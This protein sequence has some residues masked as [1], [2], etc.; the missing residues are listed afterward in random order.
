[1][2]NRKSNWVLFGLF[3]IWFIIFILFSYSHPR[4]LLQD[5]IHLKEGQVILT[6]EML[7]SNGQVTLSGEW[8]FYWDQQLSD[9][10]IA[11]GDNNSNIVS[12]P[13][14]W[15]RYTHNGK[16]LP[17]FGHGTYHLKIFVEN[18]G[19]YGIKIPTLSTA[20]S[21]YIDDQLIYQSGVAG[22][23]AEQTS[24]QYKSGLVLF[25]VKDTEFDLIIHISNYLYARGGMW[26][27]LDFGTANQL[28][29]IYANEK[30]TDLFIL[31]SV[32][33][34][35]IYHLILFTMR[36]KQK[37]Y[38]LFGL[39]SL[40]VAIRMLI[41][42][43]VYLVDILSGVNVWWFVFFEYLTYYAGIPLLLMYFY[44]LYPKEFS[45]RFIKIV[46]VV[47]SLFVLTTIV[48]PVHVFTQFIYGYHFVLII[49]LFVLLHNIFKTVRHKR[50]GSGIQLIAILTFGITMIHDV[51]YNLNWLQIFNRQIVP[52]GMFTLIF[53]QA[54]LIARRFSTVY[55]DMEKATEQLLL[56]DKE[57]DTFLSNTAHELKTPLHGI[58]NISDSLLEDNTNLT[59]KQKQ[60]LKLVTSVA[61]QMSNLVQ[62]ILDFDRFNQGRLKLNKKVTD[63]TK[64]VTTN[65][66]IL[67]ALKYDD[68]VKLNVEIEPNLPKVNVDEARILQVLYNL[69]G[70]AF[71][72]TITGTVT[73][74]VHKE[75]PFI[76]VE[77]ID[78]GQGIPEDKLSTIF[79]R[80][81]QAH[82]HYALNKQGSG[83]GIGIAKQ[84]IDLHGGKIT[85]ESQVNK[86]TIVRF[87]LPIR[88]I[89]EA[90]K[91]ILETTRHPFD[92][93]SININKNYDKR[94]LH[95]TYTLLVVDDEPINLQVIDHMFSSAPYKL[96]KARNGDEALQIIMNRKDLDLIILDV[97]MPGISGYEVTKRIRQSYSLVELPI[98]LITVNNRTEDFLAGFEAGAND[99]ITKPFY[100]Q[101]M[102]A[103][104]QTLLE[105]KN[106]VEQALDSEVLS[107]QAQIKPHFL[108][109][110]LNIISSVI[111]T[112]PLKANDLLLSLAD[113]M[114]AKFDFHNRD[115]WIHID[116]EM[117]FLQ[118][119][120]IIEKA[121]FEERLTIQYELDEHLDFEIP[122]FLIQPLVENAVRHGVNKNKEGGTVKIIIKKEHKGYRITVSD[123]GIGMS[124]TK[125]NRLLNEQYV[126]KKQGIGIQNIQGRL[127]RLFGCALEIESEIGK[128]TVF[129]MLIPER[130]DKRDA[131]ANS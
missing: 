53:F 129:R 82:V 74:K 92:S 9:A 48:L 1:M 10:Q 100:S 47:S 103:R 80:Y 124:K 62:D 123:D 121:R 86:G 66:D 107:L 94:Q 51:L 36:I 91:A 75:R 26:Y 4:S 2:K 61:R 5:D 39:G 122:P 46:T 89:E 131:R 70:N 84:I 110:A 67:H 20:S 59:S 52:L 87:T 21:V 85:I 117:D 96:I 71:K 98:L 114:R 23:N 83:L 116:D 50:D 99:Y 118:S 40:F 31:G 19:M 68:R 56:A 112:E 102:K 45:L 13:D 109:N 27:A 18:P 33:I 3:F 22:T 64:I 119:Y 25:E 41:I 93:Q 7:S 49:V 97:M 113:Y 90:N 73:I 42:E 78:T 81:E 17:G 24:A 30:S 77:I 108:F 101:E 111:A 104:V 14:V 120:L 130:N 63:L 32:L 28:A 115:K 105:L 57:K 35:S 43:H 76:V 88:N 37:E 38:L 55:H 34:I 125:V 15:T 127:K 6:N 12:V 60:H 72:F 95:T 65:L 44:L 54:V 8:T 11:S 126:S 69:I 79:D 58:I 16:R 29:Q 106:S 128:G